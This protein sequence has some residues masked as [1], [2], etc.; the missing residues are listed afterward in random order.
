[1][2]AQMEVIQKV[3]RIKFIG[4]MDLVNGQ[5]SCQ[6]LLVKEC[7]LESINQYH[8]AADTL[9]LKS[10]VD[11]ILW[12]LSPYSFESADHRDLSKNCLEADGSKVLTMEIG[13]HLC[14]FLRL[15][16]TDA[17]QSHSPNFVSPPT[18]APTDGSPI[19]SHHTKLTLRHV[20]IL[21][22]WTKQ[23]E[24]S[25][26]ERNCGE[27]T[28]WPKEI[29]WKHAWM[30]KR[31]WQPVY[32]NAFWNMMGTIISERS[33]ASCHYASERPHIDHFKPSNQTKA[34]WK[35]KWHRQAYKVRQQVSAMCDHM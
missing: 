9:S 1:M 22:V 5:H 3:K 17:L 24:V 29:L 31:N 30:K 2:Q 28:Y 8:P 34:D 7:E 10:F 26:V 19:L 18:I 35:L 25:F 27:G 23:G 16:P 11:D 6:I 13:L 33:L 32:V 20:P 4:E 21:V 12:S 14:M 15:A